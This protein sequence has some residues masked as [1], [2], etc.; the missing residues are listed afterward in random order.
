MS[1]RFT[2]TDGSE[3]KI[4]FS[5]KG[6]KK[7]NGTDPGKAP[8]YTKCTIVTMNNKLI[9]EG[10]A[11]P[12]A[13]I[14]EELPPGFTETIAQK[15]YGHRLKRLT[16]RDDGKLYAVLKGDS[17]C[18]AK[19]RKESLRKALASLPKE[20]RVGAWEAIGEIVIV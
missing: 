8:R 9:G 20:D 3:A 7:G 13:T 2:L 16:I 6:G 14:L 17:F 5:H 15:F 11:A 10:K 19:G 4:Y 18:R 1:Y 12:L